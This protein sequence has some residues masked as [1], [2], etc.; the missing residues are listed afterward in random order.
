MSEELLGEL[1]GLVSVILFFA[2]VMLGLWLW[3]RARDSHRNRQAD[4]NKR[5]LEKFNSAEEYQAF[6]TS[7]E[8]QDAMRKIWS[9]LPRPGRRIAV[10]FA[11]GVVISC[12]GLGFLC[13][14]AVDDDLVIPGTIL[15]STGLGMVLAAVLL[16]RQFS[17]NRHPK[18]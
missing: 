14:I 13:L 11:W 16:R 3:A 1:I 10:F 2:L 17:R 6:I 5:L 7:T 12:A 18:P 15:V 9:D 4:F 8:G